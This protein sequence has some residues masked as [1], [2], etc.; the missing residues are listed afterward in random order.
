MEKLAILTMIYPPAH[1][2][3]SVSIA[4][5]QTKIAH[6]THTHTHTHTHIYIYMAQMQVYF[7]CLLPEDSHITQAAFGSVFLIMY[8]L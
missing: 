7:P 4:N 5:F 8:M 1:V 2:G 3:F 6:H